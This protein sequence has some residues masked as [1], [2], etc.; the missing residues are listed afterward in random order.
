MGEALSAL[1]MRNF[2]GWRALSLCTFAEAEAELVQRPG[3]GL[4]TVDPGVHD[5]HGFAGFLRLQEI[6][7]KVPILVFGPGGNAALVN[8]AKIFGA[9]GYVTRQDALGSLAAALHSAV[10]GDLVYPA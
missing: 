6:A 4:I 5:A 1:I 8:A 3:C 2:E 7:P 10:K 9:A